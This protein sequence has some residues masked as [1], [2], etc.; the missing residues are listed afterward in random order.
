MRRLRRNV[1]VQQCR[2][3]VVYQ[4]EKK[5]S[6]L[7]PQPIRARH[8]CCHGYGKWGQKQR[9]G[10]GDWCVCRTAGCSWWHWLCWLCVYTT[11]NLEDQHFLEKRSRDRLH[12]LS[13]WWLL[14]TTQPVPHLLSSFNRSSIYMLNREWD[15]IA[16][17]PIG[18]D[19]KLPR[20]TH[21][22]WWAESGQNTF[23]IFWSSST[24]QFI[25]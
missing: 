10:N 23:K 13:G 21:I 16:H 17:T 8:K 14:P 24:V 4:R 18:N 7:M 20:F 22:S 12:T 5:A 25:K 15:R 1:N 2:H 3:D 19:I 11:P 6:A 9:W